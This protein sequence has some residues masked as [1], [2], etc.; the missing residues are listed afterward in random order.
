MP[1]RKVFTV[2]SLILTAVCLIFGT[3]KIGQGIALAAGLVTL[4]VWLLAYKWPSTGLPSI[5]LVVSVGLAGTGLCLGASPV[6][7]LASATLA[8]ASWDLALLERIPAGS[9]SF[10]TI[11]LLEK[12]HYQSLLLALGVAFPVMIFGRM[13][14]VQIPFGVMILLVALACFSLARVWR[15]FSE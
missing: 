15:T 1:L 3:S 14:H 10:R 7:M 4:G 13:I 2:I 6:L 11:S 12:K 8:L 5:A 9:S